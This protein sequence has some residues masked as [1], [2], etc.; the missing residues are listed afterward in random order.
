MTAAWKVPNFAAS[1]R[2]RLL[3]IARRDGIDYNRMLQRYAIERFLYRLSAS[4]MVDRFTLKGATL[5]LIWTTRE[6]RP[7]WDI[8]FLAVVSND[9]DTIRTALKV[10]CSIPCPEDGVV[11]R[12]RVGPSRGHP[13]RSAVRRRPSANQRQ[14]GAGAPQPSSRHRLRRRHHPKTRAGGVPH[15]PRAAAPPPLDVPARDDGRREVSCDGDLGRKQLPCEGHL[16][17]HL[18]RPSLHVRRQDPA[19]RYCGDVS[20]PADIARKEEATGTAS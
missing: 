10:V 17:H 4:R 9:H 1:V 7:T 16:G 11:I 18:H 2:Q 15:A 6:L 19:I 12:P 8:D 14:S 5:L 13:G 20:T 3:N